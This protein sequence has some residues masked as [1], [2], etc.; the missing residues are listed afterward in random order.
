MRSLR[1]AA[2][3]A[4]AITFV[5][6][7]VQ[8]MGRLVITEDSVAQI[9][10]DALIGRWRKLPAGACAARYP[11]ALEFRAGGVYFAPGGPDAGAYWHGGDWRIEGDTLVVQ[12][13]NDAMVLYRLGDVSDHEIALED[14][15]GCRFTYRRDV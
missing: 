7:G 12:V 1:L 9:S 11:E 5:L 6:L 13:S 10:E 15:A 4:A 8:Y 2:A 14:D 3:L